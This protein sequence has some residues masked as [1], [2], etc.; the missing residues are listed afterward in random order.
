MCIN[1]E[2][3]I[4]AGNKSSSDHEHQRQAKRKGEK[5][6]RGKRRERSRCMS[7]TIFRLIY[8]THS[9]AISYFEFKNYY[10]TNENQ[11]ERP[12]LN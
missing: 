4:R 5:K 10:M 1:Y 7:Y 9:K 3:L 8:A 2:E 6:D 12:D 11:F